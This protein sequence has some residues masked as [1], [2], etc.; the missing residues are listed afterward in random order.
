MTPYTPDELD[1]LLQIKMHPSYGDP[2]LWMNYTPSSRSKCTP[3]Q[4]LGI[5]QL[6][7]AYTPIET[8]PLHSEVP[9]SKTVTVL[10]TLSTP[11]TMN[12]IIMS[13][14]VYDTILVRDSTQ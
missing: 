5:L 11:H 10:L 1:P 7:S 4:K 12:N 6:I 9:S 2:L 8:T 3:P 13:T 14:H